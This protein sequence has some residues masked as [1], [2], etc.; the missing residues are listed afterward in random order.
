LKEKSFKGI[1][2]EAEGGKG[3]LIKKLKQ[4]IFRRKYNTKISKTLKRVI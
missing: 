3:L 2:E 1:Y 4:R